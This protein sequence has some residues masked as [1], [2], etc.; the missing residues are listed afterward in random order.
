M[1]PDLHSA[2]SSCT[3]V[4]TDV[5]DAAVIVGGT[6]WVVPP[7]DNAALALAL[8]EAIETPPEALR[9]RGLA[10]RARIASNFSISSV[11]AQYVDLYERLV[12]DQR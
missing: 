9:A 8:I 3:C 6:G 2:V 10:A 1:S 5:G 12:R 4:T 7:R 11:V